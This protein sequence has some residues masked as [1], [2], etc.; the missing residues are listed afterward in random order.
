MSD[1]AVFRNDNTPPTEP[2]TFFECGDDG[3][4]EHD[5]GGWREIED[6]LGGERFCQKCGIGAME[7]SMRYLP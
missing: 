3:T 4:C 7:W 6:G 2:L 1:K 5:F